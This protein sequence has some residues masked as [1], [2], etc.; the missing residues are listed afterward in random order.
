MLFATLSWITTR[1]ELRGPEIRFKYGILFTE[2]KIYLVKY[3]QE[4]VCDQSLLGRIFNYGTI[5]IYNPVLKETIY[6]DAIP[7]PKRYTEMIKANLPNPKGA[8]LVPL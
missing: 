2:E 7:D 4:V 6:I 5:Q 3:S 8:E 1:Y